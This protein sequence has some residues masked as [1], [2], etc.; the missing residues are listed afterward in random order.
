MATTLKGD[1]VSLPTAS[2]NPSSPSV[3]EMYFNTTDEKTM[4]YQ[5]ATDGWV[6]M[7]EQQFSATGG[8]ESSFAEGGKTSVVRVAK[9]MSGCEASYGGQCDTWSSPG[10]H[11]CTVVMNFFSSVVG[12]ICGS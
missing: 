6:A 10:M 3:G 5:N 8:T 2:S 4:I 1:R 11:A 12:F 7:N 9:K